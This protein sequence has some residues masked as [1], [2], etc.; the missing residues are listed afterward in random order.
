MT[1]FLNPFR[2]RPQHRLPSWAFSS[3]P[4]NARQ[5]AGAR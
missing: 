2:K 5:P 3:A 1:F 4:A